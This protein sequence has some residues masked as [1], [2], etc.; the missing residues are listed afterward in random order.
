LNK[1]TLHT[2]R[3][4][5]YQDIALPISKLLTI[6]QCPTEWRRC[7]LYLFRD[8]AIVFYVGQSHNAFDRVWAHLHGGFKGRSVVGRFVLCNWPRSMRFVVE[9][10]HSQSARFDPVG[11]DLDAAERYLIEQLS[12]CFNEALNSRPTPLPGRYSPPSAKGRRPKSIKRMMH[13]AARACQ[14]EDNRKQ[15][16]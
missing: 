15:W 3:E 1:L 4:P 7:D 6:E 16:A 2:S 14:L 12:P 9:L 10:M 13:D 5:D 8:D 11:N